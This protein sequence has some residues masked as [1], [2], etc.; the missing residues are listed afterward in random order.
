MK[1]QKKRQVGIWIIKAMGAGAIAVAIL[2]ILCLF[3]YNIPIHQENPNGT[4]DYIWEREKFYSRGTEGF[5]W[6]KTDKNGYNNKEIP[7]KIDILLMGSSHMEA[8]NVSQNKNT[9]ALLQDMLKERGLEE[10]VYNIGTSGHEFLRCLSN[11]EAALDVY[12]PSDYIIIE[13]ANLDF[14]LED[15][16]LLKEK[17]YPV[18]PSKE[19]GVIGLLQKFP[20]L[21]LVYKQLSEW[22]EKQ[23]Q[24]EPGKKNAEV[25]DHE[26]DEVRK[27]QILEE[28]LKE[29]ADNIHERGCKLIIFYHPLLGIN[30]E[31]VYDSTNGLKREQFS[32]LCSQNEIIFLDMSE[33]FL[34]EYENDNILPHGFSNTKIEAGHLNQNGHRMIAE[35]LFQLIKE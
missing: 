3:Y 27:N 12:Q 28:I 7:E 26:A 13:T 22:N 20:Y 18:L 31:E 34:E 30:E 16:E 5:A 29:C 32:G 1:E 14:S 2:N 19:G 25:V 11:I 33:R 8:F 10:G 6:G 4:T 24:K 17:Q 21:R 15:L 9:A 23:K 35:E